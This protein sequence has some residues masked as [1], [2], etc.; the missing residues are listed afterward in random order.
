MNALTSQQLYGNLK[1]LVDLINVYF[2]VNIINTT[3][4]H[5][6]SGNYHL[7]LLLLYAKRR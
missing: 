4:N 1:R 7:L 2:V 6:M 3:N 5:K